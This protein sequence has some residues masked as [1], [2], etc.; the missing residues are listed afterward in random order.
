[1]TTYTR[2]EL[3]DKRAKLI[4]EIAQLEKRT[5]DLHNRLSYI[6]ASIRILWP[7]EELPNVVLR[8]DLKPRHF[9]RGHLARL[10]SEFMRDHA[11]QPVTVADIMIIAGGDR[12][13][14][15]AERRNIEVVVYNALKRLAKRRVINQ[16][17]TRVKGSRFTLT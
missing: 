7:G 5:R 12:T 11:G 17:G 6:E 9:K 1:M 10:V 8:G 4:G 14:T 16:V 15:V 3:H 2:K 13:L